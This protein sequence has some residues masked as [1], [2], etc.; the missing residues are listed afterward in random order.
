MEVS[1]VVLVAADDTPLVDV[2]VMTGVVVEDRVPFSA[3]IRSSAIFLI[4]VNFL[5]DVEQM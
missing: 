5:L 1:L 2:D 3:A 4:N